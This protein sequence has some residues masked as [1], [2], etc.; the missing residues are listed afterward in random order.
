MGLSFACQCAKSKPLI[1]TARQALAGGCVL[2]STPWSV[3]IAVKD[4]QMGDTQAASSCKFKLSQIWI[5]FCGVH[6]T[7][8]FS[9]IEQ[10]FIDVVPVKVK[11]SWL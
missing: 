4:S 8:N 5:C 3:I 11:M 6:A 2:L 7:L 10:L 1:I 9:E